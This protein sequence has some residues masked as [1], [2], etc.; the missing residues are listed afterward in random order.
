MKKLS[1]IALLVVF[2]VSAMA[3]GMAPP[4]KGDTIF[5]KVLP[6][7]VRT[8]E[9]VIE[10]WINNPTA[11]LG[12]FGFDLSL[13]SGSMDLVRCENGKLT[14][15]FFAVLGNRIDAKTVRIG[16]IP[17]PDAFVPAKSNGVIARLVFRPGKLDSDATLKAANFQ[18]TKM[19]DTAKK[20]KPVVVKKVRGPEIAK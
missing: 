2:S 13:K 3:A 16:G 1:L 14:K 18:F 6:Q 20:F 5:L 17:K 12:P 8:G 10:V 11:E 4:E 9:T 19:V 7:D 15:E